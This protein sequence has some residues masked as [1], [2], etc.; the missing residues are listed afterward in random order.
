MTK[1]SFS[2]FVEQMNNKN[3]VDLFNDMGIEVKL[4]SEIPLAFEDIE[5]HIIDSEFD[6]EEEGIL[7]DEL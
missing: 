4:D 6:D 7:F 5:Q 3:V 2:Q 1:T